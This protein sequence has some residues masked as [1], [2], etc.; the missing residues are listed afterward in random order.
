VY[1]A[2][3]E[4]K[5]LIQNTPA[6]GVPMH[7]R[8]A[9]TKLMQDIGYGDGY[10]YA[11]DEDDNVT[12]QEDLPE[13]LKGRVFYRPGKFGFEKDVNKR[14]EYWMKRKRNKQRK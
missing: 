6:Y 14:I 4:A 9:P 11:H 8:N 13:E 3:K 10:Q 2:C 1:R 5:K 12:T 7:L